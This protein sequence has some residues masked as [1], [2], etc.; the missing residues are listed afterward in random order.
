[1][2]PFLKEIFSESQL[3]I[4]SETSEVIDVQVKTNKILVD[5][6]KQFMQI[7]Y[8]IEG[9]LNNLSGHELKVKLRV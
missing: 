1:M 6:E 4:D 8:H 9:I 2:T 3:T 7:Y 5:N